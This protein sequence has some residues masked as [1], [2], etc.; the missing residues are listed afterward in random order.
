MFQY[1]I[2][3]MAQNCEYLPKTGSVDERATLVPHFGFLGRPSR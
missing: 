1:M 3:E 2:F